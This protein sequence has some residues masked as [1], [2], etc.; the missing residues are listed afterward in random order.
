MFRPFKYGVVGIIALFGVSSSAFA[1]EDVSAGDHNLSADFTQ[2]DEVCIFCH[3]PH[4]SD[5][6]TG[7]LWNRTTDS[8][9]FTMY[10]SATIDMTIAGAPQGV[11]LACLSCH[12]GSIGFNEILNGPTLTPAKFMTG[13][14]NLGKDL[15]GDHPISVT[16]NTALDPGFHAIADVEAAGLKLYGSG[17][18]QVECGSCHNPHETT[19]KF[20]R[21]P[22]TASA[23]CLTCH[24]K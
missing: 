12:D 14:E 11:S 23:L 18:D 6:T 20:L 13:A 17:S 22:N 7:V 10:G 3:T 9:G 8:T 24:I 1:V 2:T 5:T 15:S 21:M 19:T 4:N 16:Y